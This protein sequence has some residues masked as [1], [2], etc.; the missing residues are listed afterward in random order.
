MSHTTRPCTTKFGTA[1][2]GPLQK[3]WLLNSIWRLNSLPSAPMIYAN[4]GFVSHKSL[5]SVD[6]ITRMHCTATTLPSQLRV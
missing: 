6:V 1:R 2:G 5:V 4:F 3:P